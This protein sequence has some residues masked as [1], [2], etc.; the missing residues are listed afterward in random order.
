[1]T[2]YR[3]I[4]SNNIYTVLLSKTESFQPSRDSIIGFIDIL[5]E[6][7]IEM[8]IVI[9]SFP[10][11]WANIIHCTSGENSVRLPAIYIHPD[12]ATG[13]GFYPIFSNDGNE[14][15]YK[16]TN[17]ALVT[18]ETYHLEMDFT[19]STHKVTL[20]GEIKADDFKETHDTY[21]LENITC[22]ASDPWYDAADVTISN[23]IIASMLMYVCS[24][25]MPLT[26][27]MYFDIG[28]NFRE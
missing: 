12:S 13:L 21:L 23:L 17:D 8:D 20:N 18:G 24:P 16:R 11:D 5:D 15:Y 2:L 7:H 25:A 4:P 9:H 28:Y 3:F 14:N 22:Y 19:Q 1:M 26:P 27:P 10:S 6:M